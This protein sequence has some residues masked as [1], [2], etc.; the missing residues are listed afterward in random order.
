MLK[1]RPYRQV[2][3]KGAQTTRGK[4][5]KRF[6]GPFQVL[7]CIGPVTYRL[8][9]LKEARIHSVFHCSL[10]KAFKGSLDNIPKA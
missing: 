9:L 7:E 1:L 3:A 2:S 8:Q 4:L 6:Y 5:G 10:L